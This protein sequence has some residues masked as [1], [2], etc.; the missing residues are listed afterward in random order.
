MS[1]PF[2]DSLKEQAKGQLLS[3]GYYFSHVQYNGEI[4]AFIRNG[5]I[6][7]ARIDHGG[8]IRKYKAREATDRE[9]QLYRKKQAS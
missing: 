2:R 3:E 6:Y 7:R 9:K 1:K 8:I 4:Y 5:I